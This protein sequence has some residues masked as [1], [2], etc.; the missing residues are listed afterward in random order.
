M[1]PGGRRWG[2]S[3][4]RVCSTAARALSGIPS[5]VCVGAQWASSV[6]HGGWRC[7]ILIVKPEP[8]VLRK[9]LRYAPSS[10]AQLGSTPGTTLKHAPI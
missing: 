2:A 3:S 1:S 5:E 4:W 10:I 9:Y 7:A 8:I 6:A